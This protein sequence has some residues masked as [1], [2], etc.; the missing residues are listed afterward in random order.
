MNWLEVTV[1]TTDAGIAPVCDALSSAGIDSV[2]IE[3]SAAAAMA[4]LNERTVYWDFVDTERIGAKTPCVKAYLADVPES[5]SVVSDIRAAIAHLRTLALTDDPGTLGVTVTRVD[6]SE[7][8]D[9]WKAYYQPF[10]IGERL[11]IVPSWERTPDAEGRTVLSL[12][13]GVAFGTG[14]HHTTRMCLELLQTVVPQGG[15]ALDLGCGSGILSIAAVLLGAADALAVDIDPVAEHIARENAEKNGLPDA[16]FT[17]K[18]GDAAC[19][20]DF[21]RTL[22]GQYDLVLANIVSDVIIRL[23]PFM[24][25]SAKPGAPVIVSGV[26][27]ERRDEVSARMRE[28]GF[29]VEAVSE[30]GGWVA[31]LARG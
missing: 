21:Q 17:V 13:P 19:D 20:A 8:K 2:S 25:E 29:A 12:D 3:E 27:D 7:W 26:I 15:H 11:M 24:K 9:N 1:F 18:I 30:S 10:P 4:F 28:A 5:E 31:I 23:L 14:T 22:T 6:D 16:R